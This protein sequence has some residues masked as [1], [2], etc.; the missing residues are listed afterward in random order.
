[1]KEKEESAGERENEGN[2]ST[3]GGEGNQGNVPKN[4]SDKKGV[5]T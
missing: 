4:W 3:A 2:R 1:M 5:S